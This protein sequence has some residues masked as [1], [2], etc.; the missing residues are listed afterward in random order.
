MRRVGYSNQIIEREYRLGK[1]IRVT[2]AVGMLAM[3]F[4]VA[5]FKYTGPV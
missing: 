2:Q 3:R 4:V 5:L 1:L